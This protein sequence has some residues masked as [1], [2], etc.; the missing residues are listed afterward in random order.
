M[1][2]V[3]FIHLEYVNKMKLVFHSFINIYIS[4][5]L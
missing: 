2:N 3:S 5:T 1:D 4:N